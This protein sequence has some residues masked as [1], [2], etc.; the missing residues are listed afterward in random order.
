MRKATIYRA[1]NK[2][3][4]KE[5]EGTAKELAAVIGCTPN[6]VNKIAL[7]KGSVYGWRAVKVEE[8]ERKQPRTCSDKGIPSTLLQEW[9]D[10]TKL[11]RR[12]RS[13]G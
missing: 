10:V 11:F 2:E 4:E 6:T 3:K 13:V 8:I 12:K 1:T 9:E 7:E 5:I